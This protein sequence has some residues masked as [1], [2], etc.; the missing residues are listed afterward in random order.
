VQRLTVSGDVVVGRQSLA[1]VGISP[2]I[3]L[4]GHRNASLAAPPP[5]RTREED[6]PLV[7]AVL[8]LAWV[9]ICSRLL[10]SPTSSDNG[11]HGRFIAVSSVGTA[12]ASLFGD[13]SARFF[14][15]CIELIRLG[16]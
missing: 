5:K 7:S 16:S 10:T 1:L 4:A 8:R 13:M 3:L 2:K 15:V 6:H 14:G 12:D 9:K 11:H